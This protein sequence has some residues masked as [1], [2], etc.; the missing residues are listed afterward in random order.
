[1]I[2][3]VKKTPVNLMLVI[4]TTPSVS[5]QSFS[6]VIWFRRHG[7]SIS[8]NSYQ[9]KRKQNSVACSGVASSTAAVGG[10]L[11]CH[12]GPLFQLPPTLANDISK[13]HTGGVVGLHAINWDRVY[14][15]T[16]LYNKSNFKHFSFTSLILEHTSY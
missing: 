7:F 11:N 14:I 13:L 1:M 4:L 8:E 10:C 15:T 9:L 5:M 16:K 2:N 12:P 6:K 3:A